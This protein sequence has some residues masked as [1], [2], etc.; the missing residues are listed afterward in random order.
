MGGTS[1]KVQ[2]VTPCDIQAVKNKYAT[3]TPTPTPSDGGGGTD[4]GGWRPTYEGQCPAYDCTRP[5]S[6]QPIIGTS[7]DE[8]P[9][10]FSVCGF[11]CPVLIDVEGDGLDMTG[12]SDGVRFD[13]NR[14]GVVDRL[15]WTATGA[16]DAW[17]ALD[18]NGNGFIDDGAEV[19]GNF[20]PQPSASNPNG[21]LALAVF[22][23]PSGGGNGDG[24]IDSRDSIFSAL[25]L[26]R[27]TNHNGV[28]EAGELHTLPAL[29]LTSI[30]LDYKASKR[31]DDYGNQ[32]RYRA[33]VG[34]AKGA[35]VS[36]WA[37]DVFLVSGQ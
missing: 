14:D 21:F 13:L 3:P 11:W 15:S 1:P 16:D 17:L 29:G 20:T 4:G 27:D 33:K 28:S 5:A 10:Y 9:S 35:K 34:D 19:F 7:A 30:E 6:E 31:T 25:R 36:R 24:M 12:I 2:H 37:W 32:F 22:D 18:R 8:C 26:W 23:G